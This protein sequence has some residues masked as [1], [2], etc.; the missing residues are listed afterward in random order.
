MESVTTST[1][2][3]R[4]SPECDRVGK[5]GD[6][7]LFLMPAQ[8]QRVQGKLRF[9]RT[10]PALLIVIN[11]G[12]SEVFMIQMNNA[13][14]H[15]IVHCAVVQRRRA[16]VCFSI[17]SLTASRPR[18]PTSRQAWNKDNATIVAIETTTKYSRRGI[19]DLHLC[20]DKVH[21]KL[22]RY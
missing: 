21:R 10:S 7:V 17:S 20:N 19:C 12:Y 3:S 2:Y 22:L 14:V 15:N 6:L 8:P 5:V 9:L 11:Y 1:F 13:E 16:C 4:G 18:V